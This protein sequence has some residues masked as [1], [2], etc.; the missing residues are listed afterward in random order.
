MEFDEKLNELKAKSDLNNNQIMVSQIEA[1][2]EPSSDE[3]FNAIDVL[4]DMNISIVP[5]VD[6]EKINLDNEAIPTNENITNIYLRDIGTVK[7]L[8]REEE[9]ELAKE[10]E[11]GK[12]AS[13]EIDNFD[14]NNDKKNYDDL[15]LKVEGGIIA[16]D[17]LVNANLRLVVYIAKKYVGRG[18]SFQDL[19][20]AGN[21]GLMKAAGK[22]DYK[23]NCQFSTYATWWIK[24]SILKEI[25]ENT[26]TIRI[27][28]HINDNLIKYN[29][30]RTELYNELG[31]DATPKEIAEALNIPE[32]RV[33]ELMELQKKPKSLDDEVGEDEE[34]SFGDFVPDKTN[35]NPYKY[36]FSKFRYKTVNKALS[37]LSE[38]EK[39]IMK[40]RFGFDGLEPMTLDDIGKQYGVTREAVRQQISRITKKLKNSEFGEELKEL[41]EASD[42]EED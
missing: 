26:R 7:L 8:S 27:P 22:F 10:I 5:D 6:D 30:C 2:F 24:Q 12:N 31:R 14:I 42:D 36:T 4:S 40:K 25:A 18:M 3:Y 19:I 13:I 38:K 32:A 17:K 28:V 20:Q 15:V 35:P 9:L 41:W 21:M 37:R 1:L 33:Y 23:L 29:R 34:S 39:D 16:K 11:E